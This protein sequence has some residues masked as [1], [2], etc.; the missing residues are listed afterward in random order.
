MF[1]RKKPVVLA[2]SLLAVLL[3]LLLTGCGISVNS[4]NSGDPVNQ[5][6]DTV[7]INDT[8]KADKNST[9]G[10]NSVDT[11]DTNDT[12]RVDEGST[13]SESSAD[14]PNTNDTGRVDEGNT[15]S[16]S[17]ADTPNTN[18]T[19][20]AD[21][22]STTGEDGAED[23]VGANGEKIY[24]D[25]NELILAYYEA[26]NNV[27]AD[28]MYVLFDDEFQSE[29]QHMKDY[30][31][32]RMKVMKEYNDEWFG[33]DWYNRVTA[34]EPELFWDNIYCIE[35]TIDGEYCDYL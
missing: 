17:S 14:T 20:R 30:V 19:G 10:K 28:A 32:E 35:V 25:Y 1:N 6:I 5:P 33:G 9:T 31:E 3:T 24:E 22:G 26:I 29:T 23:E 34:G 27:D 15:T 4:T 2:L 18:D 12:G 21:E 13:T 7:G 11:P 16:E 8:D